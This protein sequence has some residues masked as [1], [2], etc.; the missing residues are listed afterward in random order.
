MAHVRKISRFRALY[1]Q[2]FHWKIAWDRCGRNACEWSWSIGSARVSLGI[3]RSRSKDLQRS[4]IFGPSTALSR[5]QVFLGTC[6][7]IPSLPFVDRAFLYWRLAFSPNFPE[8]F[9]SPTDTH[10]PRT[11]LPSLLKTI[12]HFSWGWFS[13][14]MSRGC[15][16]SC[17]LIYL[18]SAHLFFS[19]LQQ[20]CVCLVGP[21]QWL[22]KRHSVLRARQHDKWKQSQT[23][24]K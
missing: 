5:S 17:P 16:F 6:S 2:T 12:A 19:A 22:C 8:Q 18:C 13:L 10:Y 4:L 24:P 23:W 3:N 11:A 9:K 1:K 7:S 14:Q 15:C 21:P 20:L